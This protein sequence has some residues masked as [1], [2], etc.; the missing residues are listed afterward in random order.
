MN[1]T[2]GDRSQGL[3]ADACRNR[4][5]II[6][7]ARDVFVEQGPDATFDSIA[8]RAGVGNATL[9]RHFTGHQ[10]LATVVTLESLARITDQAETAL[11]YEDAFDGLQQFVHRSA[12]ERIGALCRLLDIDTSVPELFEARMRLERAVENI[13]DRARRT[14]QLR[15][16]VGLG[17][18][19]AAVTQLTRPLP[20][21]ACTDFHR[22]TH[23]HLQLFL[24]GLAAPP[25]STLP[26]AAAT[27]DDLRDA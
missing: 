13:M 25:R 5:R 14:G 3:R 10:D 21:T 23:R 6:D 7:A 27:F 24:D 8:N 17:D 20:G 4:Q 16:D 15:P 2:T 1:T 11:T 19:L 18:V 22:F 12:D 26:G 9:Y